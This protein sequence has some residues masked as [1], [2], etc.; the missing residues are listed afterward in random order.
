MIKVTDE[1]YIGVE[2][3][4]VTVYTVYRKLIRRRKKDGTQY[5]DYEALG[6]LS[7]LQTALEFIDDKIIADTLKDVS[8]GLADALRRVQ[9]ARD[10]L[11]SVIREAIPNVKF[12]VED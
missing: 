9:E 8:T 12:H 4:A 3:G 11:C 7:S 1:Y 5:E 10:E 2:N 6:Y